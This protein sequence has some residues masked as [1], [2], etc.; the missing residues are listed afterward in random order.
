MLTGLAAPKLFVNKGYDRRP[1][2]GS[3][4]SFF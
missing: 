4:A 1:V 2:S 3:A